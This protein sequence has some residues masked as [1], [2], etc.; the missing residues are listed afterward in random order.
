M[1]DLCGNFGTSTAPIVEAVLDEV[2]GGVVDVVLDDT[3]AA[4]ATV[5]LVVVEPSA[6]ALPEMLPIATSA[7]ATA[8]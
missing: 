8:T 7:A 4:A 5:V 6:L 3:G 2:T 1:P